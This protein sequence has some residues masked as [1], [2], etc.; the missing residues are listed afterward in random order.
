MLRLRSGVSKIWPAEMFD[1]LCGASGGAGNSGVVG[2]RRWNPLL[3]SQVWN[4]VG[5]MCWWGGV[6]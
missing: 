1:L 4:L 5:G 2:K 3:N 6:H